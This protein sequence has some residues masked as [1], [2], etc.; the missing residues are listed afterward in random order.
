MEKKRK[1]ERKKCIGGTIE[2]KTDRGRGGKIQWSTGGKGDFRG[3]T[4]EKKT[5]I[6]LGVL[7]GDSTQER[8][9][10][11]KKKK[12]LQKGQTCKRRS[13][14]GR[15]GAATVFHKYDKKKKKGSGSFG[16]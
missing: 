3:R 9:N 13:Y 5:T 10:R 12:K 8:G 2:K 1:L 16:Y 4:S 15:T 6:K 7:L 14:G 11:Q